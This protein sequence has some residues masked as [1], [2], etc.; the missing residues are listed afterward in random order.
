[1]KNTKGKVLL[2]EDEPHIAEGIKY[3][4]EREGF[5]VEV[6]DD[7]VKA[8][9]MLGIDEFGGSII[10]YNLIILDLMLPK[11]DGM[12]ILRLIRKSSP[13]IPILILSSK[14]AIADKIEGLKDGANDYLCKPFHL[15]ELYLRCQK[16][17]QISHYSS[18]Q[19][20]ENSLQ[21]GDNLIRIDQSYVM[22]DR[23]RIELTQLELNL[24]LFFWRNKNKVLSREVILEKVFGYSKD[25]ESRTLD[26]YMV[27][28]RKYF[29]KNP[30][31]PKYFVSIRGRGYKLNCDS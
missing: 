27:R 20:I 15:E 22:T 11:I 2:V 23:G 31:R 26:N 30:K 18:E 7:G 4:F 24:I 16:L 1:M 13:I 12:K 28:F 17:I 19:M 10:N 9:Q 6:A 29:E 14:D 25:S 21:I 3:N 5:E 8:L